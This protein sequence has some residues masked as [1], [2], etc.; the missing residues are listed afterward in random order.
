[1]WIKAMSTGSLN[2]PKRPINAP[3]Q[4][5][6]LRHWA[7]IEMV[8]CVHTLWKEISFWYMLSWNSLNYFW[9]RNHQSGE[10]WSVSR[11][12][13]VFVFIT[14]LRVSIAWET[15]DICKYCQEYFSAP[16]HSNALLPWI[17]SDTKLTDFNEAAVVT[18]TE[19]QFLGHEVSLPVLQLDDISLSFSKPANRSKDYISSDDWMWK[20]HT[21]Y[22]SNSKLREFEDSR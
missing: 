7:A 14:S 9:Q 12:I 13:H 18:N 1:M 15:P 17:L 2:Y 11:T 10:K 21:S 5:R 6:A 4:A 19:W 20:E 22:L 16:L 3:G 8:T